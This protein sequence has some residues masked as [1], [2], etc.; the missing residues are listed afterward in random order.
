[1]TAAEGGTALPVPRSSTPAAR[2]RTGCRC[3]ARSGYTGTM[4][5]LV[6]L[7]IFYTVLVGLAGLGTA[8]VAI[9]VITNLFKTPR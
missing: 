7:E 8:G 6:M 5:N 3:A 1:M 2:A 9:K 4:D